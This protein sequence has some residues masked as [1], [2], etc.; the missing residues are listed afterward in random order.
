MSRVPARLILA[1][2]SHL[3]AVRVGMEEG[4]LCVVLLSNQTHLRH[5]D[6][7]SIS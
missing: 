3:C 4:R 5:T 2:S 6:V 7:S 1:Q